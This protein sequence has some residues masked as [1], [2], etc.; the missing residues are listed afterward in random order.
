MEFGADVCSCPGASSSPSYFSFLLLVKTRPRGPRGLNPFDFNWK[1]PKSVRRSP[2]HILRLLRIAK[3]MFPRG[4]ASRSLGVS[5]FWQLETIHRISTTSGRVG[6]I[7]APIYDSVHDYCTG[8]H[9]PSRKPPESDVNEIE[10]LIFCFRGSEFG[11]VSGSSPCSYS[12]KTKSK[13]L[14][15][16]STATSPTSVRPPLLPSSSSTHVYYSLHTDRR[17]LASSEA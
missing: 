7:F 2:S 6:F 14:S 11:P 5:K 16:T 1:S 8:L 3:N 12:T 15:A 10:V 9:C 17:F 4:S 13:E